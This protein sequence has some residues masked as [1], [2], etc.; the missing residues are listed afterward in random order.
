MWQ[1]TI[2]YESILQGNKHYIVF[3]SPDEHTLLAFVNDFL[4]FH[5]GTKQIVL[6]IA[7]SNNKR[8]E[9]F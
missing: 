6:S 3:E 5:D 2:F 7:L 9:K 8:H 4:L 1:L